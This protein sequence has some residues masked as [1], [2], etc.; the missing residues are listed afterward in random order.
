MKFQI[1]WWF[2]TLQQRMESPEVEVCEFTPEKLPSKKERIVLQASPFQELCPPQNYIISTENWWLGEIHVLLPSQSLTARPWKVTFRKGKDPLPS[3][4]FAGAMSNF[5][6]LVSEYLLKKNTDG[7]LI[8]QMSWEMDLP[9]TK[10]ISDCS[11]PCQFCQTN[12]C[13][14]P[15]QWQGVALY[16]GIQILMT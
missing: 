7:F 5:G 12:T 9:S 4:I 13:V 2:L 15:S 16:E 1:K 6:R 14:W 11:L 8:H 10:R 3:T